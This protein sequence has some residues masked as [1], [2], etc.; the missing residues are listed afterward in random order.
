[1]AASPPLFPHK[2]PSRFLRARERLALTISSHLL[3]C[4]AGSSAVMPRFAAGRPEFFVSERDHPCRNVGRARIKS[5]EA[6]KR[7]GRNVLVFVL[8]LVL[9]IPPGAAES[10][11]HPQVQLRTQSK[12]VRCHPASSTYHSS[13][14]YKIPFHWRARLERIKPKT[15][16]V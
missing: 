12:K 15:G 3:C 10:R 5:G 16:A 14:K 7:S 1:M 13:R 9:Q 6:W 8:V 2:K 4:C 11:L